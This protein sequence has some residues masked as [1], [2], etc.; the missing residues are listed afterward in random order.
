MGSLGGKENKEGK[1]SAEESSILST[2]DSPRIIIFLLLKKTCGIFYG[3]V[4]SFLAF[5]FTFVQ[6]SNNN[7]YI[8]KQLFFSWGKYEKNLTT[9]DSRYS[10]DS[11]SNFCIC[12]YDFQCR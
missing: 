2:I 1:N 7:H 9:H 4:L 6:K 8:K 5:F 10:T 11:S 3:Y 12:L